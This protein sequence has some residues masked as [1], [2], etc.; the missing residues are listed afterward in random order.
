MTMYSITYDLIKS[1]DYQKMIEGIKKV[2]DDV[3]SRPTRSQ[4]IISSTKTSGQI[5][6]YLRNYMDSDDVLFVIEIKSEN[7]SS[8][9]IS[10]EVENWLNS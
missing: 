4:W 10:K 5:R 9:N 3:W 1:K 7:W 6:D 2:S 8:W